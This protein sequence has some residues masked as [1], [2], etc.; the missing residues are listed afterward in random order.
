M[1]SWPAWEP[2]ANQPGA[3]ERDLLLVTDFLAAM[4]QAAARRLAAD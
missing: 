4:A 3:Q 1:L 2:I